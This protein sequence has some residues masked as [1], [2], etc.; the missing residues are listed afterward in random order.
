[1][2][3]S[4]DELDRLARAAEAG[5]VKLKTE[6]DDLMQ[7]KVER[8]N[9]AQAAAEAGDVDRYM[10]L[11]AAEERLDAQIF[12]KRAQMDK[13][14]SP[15]NPEDVVSAW[16]SYSKDYSRDFEKLWKQYLSARKSLYGLFMQVVSAQNSALRVRERCGQLA[17][18]DPSTFHMQTID[19]SNAQGLMYRNSQLTMADTVFFQACGEAAADDGERFNSVIRLKKSY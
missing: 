1:M 9:E 10:E 15:V 3:K 16:D 7:Q 11:H 12:V 13:A 6:I 18:R 19:G 8:H 17:G 14:V 4:F 5:K 2:K